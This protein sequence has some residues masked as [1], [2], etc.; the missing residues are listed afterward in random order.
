MGPSCN[1]PRSHTA[2]GDFLALQ[3]TVDHGVTEHSWLLHYTQIHH[4]RL[5]ICEE[6]V[7]GGRRGSKEV[8]RGRRC[9]QRLVE[10]IDNLRE[11]E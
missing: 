7:V 8:N 2:N 1:V 11:R 4:L 5:S 3:L 6:G 10:V 9:L